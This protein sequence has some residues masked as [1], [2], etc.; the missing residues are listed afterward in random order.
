MNGK[1]S[2]PNNLEAEQALL[3]CLLMDNETQNEILETL[4]EDDFY[5]PSHRL[6]L[7][8]MRRVYSARHAVDAVTLADELDRNNSLENAGG[9]SYITE[10]V[11]VLPSASNYRAYYSIVKRDSV[12]RRLIRAAQQIS[13]V[14][15]ENPES[16]ESVMTAEKLIFDISKQTDTSTLVDMRE[17]T[18]YTDV[19]NK[20]DTIARDRDS[21]R[22]VLSG[23]TKLDDITNGFQK[24]DFIVLAARPGVGKTTLGMNI[25]EHA[26]VVCGK[27]CAVFSLEMPRN[28]LAQRLLCSHAR[29]SMSAALSGTLEQADWKKLWKAQDDLR[30]AKIFIDDSSKI[31]VAQILSKCRRLKARSG[32]GLDLVMVDYI[33]LMESGNRKRE[34]N[35]Q[36]EISTITRNLKIMAK[37]LEVPVLALSQ[38]RR[39]SNKEEPQLSDLRESGAIEQDAD[40]VMFIHRPDLGATEE[41]FNSGRVKKDEADL[42][43]AKHRNGRTGK[44]KLRFRGD[45]VRYVNPPPGYVPDE[46]RRGDSPKKQE[47]EPE[48]DGGSFGYVPEDIPDPVQDYEDEEYEYGDDPE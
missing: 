2:L 46:P 23:F 8:A 1:T 36:Q 17:D 31:T 29:V 45:Q 10:L 12:N 48:E 14:C 24:S 42:I 19:L 38:L 40:I 9:L 41:D 33:Q 25:V 28:Q 11:G 34:E 21:L 43:I 32:A 22:G 5:Q 37:E 27:S 15:Y 16:E 4:E 47:K 7:G 44:V 30:K 3:G 13:E 20:F 18:A 39:I 26:S 6:I 35:R